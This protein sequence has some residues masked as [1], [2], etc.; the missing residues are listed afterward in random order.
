ME[1]CVLVMKHGWVREHDRAKK[2]E[3]VQR[4]RDWKLGVL[5]ATLV[6]ATVVALVLGKGASAANASVNINSRAMVRPS[7][8]QSR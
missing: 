8:A 4:D 7:A 1:G 6:A 2:E 5:K 3:T